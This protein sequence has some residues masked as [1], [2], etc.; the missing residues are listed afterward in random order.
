MTGNTYRDWRRIAVV[1]GRIS[2]LWNATPGTLPSIE[3]TLLRHCTPF[4][5]TVNLITMAGMDQPS[6]A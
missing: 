1:P 2:L 4:T 6:E 3:A 5:V